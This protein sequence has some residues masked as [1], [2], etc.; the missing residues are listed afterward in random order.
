MDTVTETSFSPGLLEGRTHYYWQIVEQTAYGDVAGLVWEF[1]TFLPG[2]YN[3]DGTV[4][5]SDINTFANHWLES[6]AGPDYDFNND[7]IAN[8]SDFSILASYWLFP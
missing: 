3:G 5:L 8:L 4:D 6:G 1:T 7:G 2:D